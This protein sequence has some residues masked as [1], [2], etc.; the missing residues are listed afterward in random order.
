MHSAVTSPFASTTVT[1][2]STSSNST[3]R[4]NT[5]SLVIHGL[6]PASPSSQLPFKLTD[7]DLLRRDC[8]VHGEWVSSRSNKRFAVLDPG[9]GRVWATCPD[10]TRDDVHSVIKSSF[11]AFQNFSR[12][13][14]ARERARLL[15][16]WHHL[17]LASRQDLATILVHE[18]GK[19]LNEALA[20]VDYGAG[21]TSRPGSP[22]AIAG[23]IANYVSRILP[24]SGDSA[25]PAL[26]TP[27]TGAFLR[28]R[29]AVLK[30]PI[31]VVLALVPWSFPLALTL[32]K[33]A[34]ALAAGCTVIVKPSS[35]TPISA[36]A[37][38]CLA[39][40]AGFPAGVLNVLTTSLG[41]TPAVSEALCM[42]PLI[43]SVT[44]TGSARV[45]KRVAASCTRNLKRLSLDI[46][47]NC[48]FIVFNDAD[49]EQTAKDL[50]ALKWRHAGQACVA[51]NRCYVD[52]RVYESFSNLLIAEAAKL[53]LGHGMARGLLSGR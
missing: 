49:L 28:K 13:T 1:T 44:F 19:P 5:N 47:G 40:R 45:G 12:T 17:I 37:L 14:P 18:T 24:T 15:T 16:S 27:G 20:E 25:A 48:P 21:R 8:H 4:S 46:G 2:T 35:E 22:V 30:Q 9:T 6:P 39:N 23:P 42:H 51:P 43:K 26:P 34:A 36:L 32:R 31:G 29:G 3:T 38:A 50:A 33:S 11:S 52:R 41:N 10:S 53:K 7:V